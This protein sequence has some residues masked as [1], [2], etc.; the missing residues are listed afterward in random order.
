MPTPRMTLSLAVMVPVWAAPGCLSRLDTSGPAGVE[1]GAAA[2]AL[3]DA[4]F[5]LVPG[6]AGGRWLDQV[7]GP[8]AGES[9]RRTR[10]RAD[11]DKSAA[12]AEGWPRFASAAVGLP[13]RSNRPA[14]GG[15]T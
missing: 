4:F 8:E 11:G 15:R 6:G 10:S 2:G 12:R 5:G 7:F 9:D 1:V 13:A 3:I 14:C